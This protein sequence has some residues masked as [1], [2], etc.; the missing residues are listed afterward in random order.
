MRVSLDGSTV[1]G[2]GKTLE[3]KGSHGEFAGVSLLRPLAASLFADIAT[4]LEWSAETSLYYEDVYARML[5][6]CDV[7]AVPVAAGEYAEVDEPADLEQA[8]VVLDAHA[9][10]WAES[11]VGEPA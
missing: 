3:M 4:R 10:A 1:T 9:P 5:G 2:I 8:G 6:S 7:R 11:A